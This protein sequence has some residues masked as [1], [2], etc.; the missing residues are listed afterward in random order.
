MQLARAV[1]QLQQRLAARCGD[2]VGA[3]G[4]ALGR[5]PNCFDAVVAMGQ[6]ERRVEGGYGWN[7]LE[8]EVFGQG[9]GLISVEAVPKTEH[10]DV[11]AGV[12][13]GEVVHVGLDLHHVP[14]ELMP[15]VAVESV[16][17]AKFRRLVDTRSVDVAGG[18]EDEAGYGAALAGTPGQQVEG[19]D[20]VHLVSTSWI[21]V[22]RIDAG[23]RVHD[24]VDPNR[25]DQLADERVTDVE[26]QVIGTAQVVARLPGVAGDDLG[27]ATVSIPTDRTSLPMSE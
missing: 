6:L 8:V 5:Q 1:K 19:A 3:G 15:R 27:G 25:S 11:D 12:A 16:V 4:A 26:L 2:V 22:E 20:H 10:E 14:H 17:S 18:L 21:H 9:L 24:G 23:Q 13:R 7:H